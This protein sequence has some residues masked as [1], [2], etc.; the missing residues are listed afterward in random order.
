MKARD[1]LDVV[2]V[3][4]G[5]FP[6][7]EKA[8]RA[9]MAGMVFVAGQKAAKPGTPTPADADLTVAEPE[10]YVGRGA[11]KLEAALDAFGIDPSGRVCLDIGASTGGFTDC[12][13]QSGALRVHAIDVGHGQLDW[14][15]R[16]DPR[17]VAKEGLNARNLAFSDIGETVGLVVADV[18][19]ISLTL[20]LPPAFAL[21]Q[22]E[23]DM[24]VL[25]K[26]QF[27]LSAREVGKGGVVRD[28]EARLRARD[29]VEKFVG[30]AGH[31]WLG[32]IDSPLPGREGNVEFLAHLRP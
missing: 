24:V 9:V 17:V 23:G 20:I 28:P 5:F 6:T 32:C 25:I 8:R 13:L 10:R 15:I 18:S 2:L 16:E 26:P 19:F 3:A 31:R 30:Q 4:R 1:R 27:E 11:Y 22:P 29:R 12:L 7:R 14:R 21:L